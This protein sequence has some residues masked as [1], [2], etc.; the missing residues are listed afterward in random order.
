MPVPPRSKRFLD[1]VV[2][3][4]FRED[5]AFLVAH[6]AIKRAET[7]VF[8]AKVGVV[9]VAIDDIGDHAFGMQLT[10]ERVGRHAD[11]DQIVAGEQVERLLACHHAGLLPNSS[12]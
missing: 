12:G 2:D 1:L 10:A 3:N 7:A 11:S 4:F 6:R 9:D 5:V 8:R